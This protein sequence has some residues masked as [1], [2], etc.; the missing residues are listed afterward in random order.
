MRGCAHRVE[1]LDMIWESERDPGTKTLG[2]K[3]KNRIS[4][5]GREA[6]QSLYCCLGG[7]DLGDAL[8]H[9]VRVIRRC[10]STTERQREGVTYKSKKENWL[11]WLPY[12]YTNRLARWL[13]KMARR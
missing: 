9:A 4:M 1:G 2:D 12:W 6:I 5:E 10:F 3:E 13:P 11:G 7:L 8:G